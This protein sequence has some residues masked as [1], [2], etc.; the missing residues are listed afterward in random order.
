MPLS[1]AAGRWSQSRYGWCRK[2]P[3]A[4]LVV[5]TNH[6]HGQEVLVSTIASALDRIKSELDRFVP[7]AVVR[8][9]LNDLA[10]DRR[11]RVL[12]PAVTTHLFLQQVLHGNTAITH[13]RHLSGR[14]FTA[15]AY[16]QARG[17]LPVEFFRRL[18]HAVV[19]RCRAEQP[20]APLAWAAPGVD[21]RHQLLDARQRGTARDVWPAQRPGGGLR[22]PRRS[23]ARRGGGRHRLPA[24]RAGC[25]DEH[26]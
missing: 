7:E 26:A 1:Y 8:R 12:T 14:D 16:C 24:A 22:L 20:P 25:S 13:L 9:L 6:P 5:L 17:R 21:R 4:M 11:D 2:R 15:S 23:P 10:G 18:R 19:E 3:P